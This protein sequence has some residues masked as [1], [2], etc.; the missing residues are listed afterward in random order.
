MKLFTDYERSV[1]FAFGCIFYAPERE[2]P[3]ASMG[4]PGL[5]NLDTRSTVPLKTA[6]GR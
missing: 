6:P 2:P 5:R 3:Q 1:K 4:L